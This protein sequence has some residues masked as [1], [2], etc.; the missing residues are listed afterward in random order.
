MSIFKQDFLFQIIIAYGKP[1]V[2]DM[3]DES[4]PE[5]ITK[6][7]SENQKSNFCVHGI[8]QD[9]T[10]MHDSPFSWLVA[11]SGFLCNVI[12]LGESYSFGV[13]LPALLEEFNAGRAT[14]GKKSKI[15]I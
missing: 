13:L 9:S 10:S 12:I 14:T 7:Q 4:A 2:E 6:C 1:P 15:A 3:G 11:I 5:T 8:R